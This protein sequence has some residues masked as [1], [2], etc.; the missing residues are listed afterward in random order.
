MPDEILERVPEIYAQED[1][2]LADKQ[3]HAKI[4]YSFS[5]KLDLVYDGV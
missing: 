2:D 4:Y 1:V 5:F 3:V